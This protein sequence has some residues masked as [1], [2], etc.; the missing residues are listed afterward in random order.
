MKLLNFEDRKRASVVCK[1]WNDVIFSRRNLRSIILNLSELP[2]TLNVEDWSIK[3]KYCHIN[4]S[5]LETENS[6][7]VFRNTLVASSETLKCLEVTIGSKCKIKDF[8]NLLKTFSAIEILHL[9]IDGE[10]PNEDF[11]FESST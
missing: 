4:A 5:D 6:W 3:R 7:T 1:L 10:I 2:D 11:F 9:K 8:Y